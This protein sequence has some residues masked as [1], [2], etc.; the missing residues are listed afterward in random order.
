MANPRTGMTEEDRSQL[1]LL[2]T[3]MALADDEERRMELWETA[4]KLLHR[5]KSVTTRLH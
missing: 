4:L 5:M 1:E 3:D 2:L